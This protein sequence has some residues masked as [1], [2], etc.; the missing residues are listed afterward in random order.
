MPMPVFNT[1]PFKPAPEP[2]RIV[3]INPADPT[4]P[5]NACT[6]KCA[7]FLSQMDQHGRRLGGACS[8]AVLASSVGQLAAQIQ[9]QRNPPP[10]PPAGPPPSG[11]RAA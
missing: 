5:S 7:L 8:L 11:P 2:S 1:C 9:I 10:G 3:G 6:D 4:P